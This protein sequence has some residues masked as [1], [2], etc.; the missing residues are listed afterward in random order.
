MNQINELSVSDKKVTLLEDGKKVR[1]AASDIQKIEF[2]DLKNKERVFVHAFD[3]QKF[4]IEQLYDGKI[5]WYRSYRA[6][7][8]DGSVQSADIL[9]KNGIRQVLSLLVNNRKN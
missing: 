2:T 9:F 1:Y 3:Y 4:L 8:Y 5:K 6:N 7:S